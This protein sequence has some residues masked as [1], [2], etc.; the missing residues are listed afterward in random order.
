MTCVSFRETTD[1]VKK[2]E[3][4]TWDKAVSVNVLELY[5]KYPILRAKRITT[6]IFPA[7]VLTNMD[8]LEDPAKGLSAKMIVPS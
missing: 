5:S 8:S 2:F 6:K 3:E 7:V 4:I 1:L